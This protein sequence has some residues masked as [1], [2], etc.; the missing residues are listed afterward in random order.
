MSLIIDALIAGGAIIDLA[1]NE[2]QTPIM[3]AVQRSDAKVVQELLDRGADCT[4]GDNRRMVPL[5][6]STIL[7]RNTPHCARQLIFN[8]ADA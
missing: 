6:T 1:D 2:G 4:I 5:M 3:S 7:V 8:T